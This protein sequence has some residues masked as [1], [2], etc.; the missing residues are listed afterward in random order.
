MPWPNASG[1]PKQLKSGWYRGA[2]GTIAPVFFGALAGPAAAG[3]GE[4]T[5]TMK[6][7]QPRDL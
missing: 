3:M 1:V 7:E 5:R 6:A 4:S 2:S